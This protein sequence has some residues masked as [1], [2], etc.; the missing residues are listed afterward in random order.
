VSNWQLQDAKARL[1][2]VMKKAA[3]EGPQHIT[4]HANQPPSFS[5]RPI[6]SVS[7]SARSGSLTSSATHR[8]KASSSI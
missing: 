2:E 6:T 3:Q 5:R 8:S 1:S 7:E 4:L